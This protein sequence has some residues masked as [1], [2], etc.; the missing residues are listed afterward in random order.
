M[1][2]FTPFQQKML[3]AGISQTFIEHYH[4]YYDQL[5]AGATGYISHD[6]AQPVDTLPTYTELDPYLPGQV[7]KP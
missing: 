7:K 3:A 5:A 4:F 1:S 2:D 6:Q